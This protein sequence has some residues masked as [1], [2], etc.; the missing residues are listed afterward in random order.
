V[1]KNYGA[2]AGDGTGRAIFDSGAIF[3]DFSRRTLEDRDNLDET[4][5]TAFCRVFNIGRN[6][7]LVSA[8]IYDYRAT[9]CSSLSRDCRNRRAENRAFSPGCAEEEGD[10]NNFES[11]AHARPRLP[12]SSFGIIYKEK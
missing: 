5:S 4:I 10:I 2:R 9:R 6:L 8:S 7:A 11:P 12:V 1:E 3:Q